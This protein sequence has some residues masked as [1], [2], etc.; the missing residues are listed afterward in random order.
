MAAA[1]GAGLTVQEPTGNMIVDIGGGTTEVAVISL[2]GIVAHRSIRVAGHEMDEAI[3]QHVRRAYNLL[4]GERTAEEIK[5]AIGAADGQVEGRTMEVRG[6]DLVTGLPKTAIVTDEEIRDALA[7]P[8]A[9]IIEAVRMTLERT[10]PELAADI[11]DRGIVLAGGGALLR[12][13]D[14]LL[15]E[16]TGMPVHI[17][18][19]PV[20]S[21][22]LGTGIALEHYDVMQR[23]L[24]NPRRHA[25]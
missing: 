17:A 10:P 3:V 22:A 25:R 12:G 6:R 7:E 18:E 24:L 19:D 1:I 13:M 20:S 2:G 8:V 14:R 4:I 23:V 21:V 9:A 15:R 11:M 16:E 5:T